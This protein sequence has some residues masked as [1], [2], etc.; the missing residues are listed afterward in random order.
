MTVQL[1]NFC[2]IS[3]YFGTIYQDVMWPHIVH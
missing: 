1:V 2:D 3:N